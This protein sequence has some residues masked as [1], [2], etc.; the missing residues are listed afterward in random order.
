MKQKVEPTILRDSGHGS[1]SEATFL[2]GPK[3]PRA[4]WAWNEATFFKGP[5]F[6]SYAERKVTL[7]DKVIRQ[8][9]GPLVFAK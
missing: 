4:P 1:Q 8:K 9:S 3:A 7:L 5:L 2:K 6:L